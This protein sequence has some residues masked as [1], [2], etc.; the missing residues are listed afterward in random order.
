M[1]LRFI[2]IVLSVKSSLSQ[3]LYVSNV[4]TQEMLDDCRK[5]TCEGSD[6]CFGELG[7]FNV[8]S[9]WCSNERHVHR[10]PQKPYLIKTQF[11]LSNK[12]NFNAT[13]ISEITLQNST[14]D[15][16]LKTKII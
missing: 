2:L 12:K 11:F 9:S 16:T 14:F 4:I 6:F 1:I 13:Q 3:I 5:Q 7:C 8:D 10:C 15:K